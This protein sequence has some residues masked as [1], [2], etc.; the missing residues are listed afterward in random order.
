MGELMLKT[1]M[2]SLED[3]AFQKRLE[4]M[5]DMNNRK[6]FSELNKL[7]ALIG[8]VNE[9][10]CQLVR[11]FNEN[12]PLQRAEQ[13]AEPEPRMAE[14]PGTESLKTESPR[15]EPPRLEPIPSPEKR[16]LREI[17]ETA[18]Y[19]SKSNGDKP[20]PRYGDYKSEDVSIDKFFY[21]G[22]K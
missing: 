3:Y 14:Q 4:L 15:I 5:M 22:K 2:G 8:S 6:M 17:R 7:N 10:V 19:A 21:F 9:N 11:L 20:K 13:R 12:R 16:E 1:E 18:S